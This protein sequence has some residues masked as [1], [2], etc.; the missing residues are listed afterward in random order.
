MEN[1]LDYWF[2]TIHLGLQMN[3]NQISAR[4]KEP[5]TKPDWII[6]LPSYNMRVLM[7]SLSARAP[8][9][10]WRKEGPRWRSRRC[11]GREGRWPPAAAGPSRSP[12]PPQTPARWSWSWT[13]R[14]RCSAGWGWVGSG[15]PWHWDSGK[16]DKGSNTRFDADSFEGGVKS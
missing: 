6:L 3:S 16:N 14:P 2:L 12:G 4:F 9:G 10:W 8:A 7:L 13:G 15:S 1:V 11:P 5:R